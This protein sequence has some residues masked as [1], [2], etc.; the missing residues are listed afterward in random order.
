MQQSFDIF[1]VSSN[2]HKYLEA[3][4]ILDSFGIRLGFL[5]QG[6]EEIQ[7]DSIKKIA[8]KKA[9]DAFSKCKKPLIIEDDG[10]FINSLDGFPGPYSSYVFQTIGNKGVLNLVGTKRSARFVSL[11]TFCDKKTTKSFEGKIDGT[12]SKKLK[13]KGWGYDPIFIPKNSSDT[14]AEIKN[15]NELSHRYKALKKFANWYSHK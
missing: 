14:F 8:T 9:K 4:T 3:K 6:L 7:S 1:F 2:K 5:K 15:K 10:L 11:I 12:I 13:G